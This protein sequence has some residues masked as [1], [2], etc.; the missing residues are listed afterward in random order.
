M[1]SAPPIE[2]GRI[3]GRLSEASSGSALLKREASSVKAQA[4][5][6]ERSSRAARPMQYRGTRASRMSLDRGPIRNS[7][8][9]RAR[10]IAG[11]HIHGPRPGRQSRGPLSAALRLC[12][13]S[14]PA[15]ASS[16]LWSSL[17]LPAAASL[18]LRRRPPPP[19]LP[20]AARAT[21]LGLTRA[22]RAGSA[23]Q[24]R[25]ISARLG[26][27]R[28]ISARLGASRRVSAHLGASRRISA[29]LGASRP[30][31]CCSSARERRR[32]AFSDMPPS[33]WRVRPERR[34]RRRVQSRRRTP[35]LGVH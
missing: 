33:R 25:R 11:P 21:P 24:A 3:G 32:T 13:R 10:R 14:I 30:P 23:H 31:A 27:S 19:V 16:P 26:A 18:L 1:R 34:T 22:A 20:P 6:F 9:R 12:R 17:A 5:S 7:A 35:V 8:A 2:K 15:S 28:R 29:R 4:R